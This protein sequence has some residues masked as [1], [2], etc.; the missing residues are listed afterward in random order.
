M[1]LPPIFSESVTARLWD[2]LSLPNCATEVL[3]HARWHCLVVLI[4][5]VFAYHLRI[6]EAITTN[7]AMPLVACEHIR[8][9]VGVSRVVF[10]LGH[11][12]NTPCI[13][14]LRS[15]RE[16]PRRR[17]AAEPRQEFSSFDMDCH[18]TLRLGVIHA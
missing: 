5:D 7:A 16:R 15:R 3:V 6:Q 12:I 2:F 17:R 14:L 10:G 9:P 11:L 18:V 8:T 1:T 4:G 13:E